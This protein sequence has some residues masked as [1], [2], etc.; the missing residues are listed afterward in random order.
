MSLS[1]LGCSANQENNHETC[2]P[3]KT[4]TAPTRSGD[5]QRCL[6]VEMLQLKTGGGA[7]FGKRALLTGQSNSS[8]E[9][10]HQRCRKFV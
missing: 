10:W 7:V 1:S 8:Y 4:P 5:H 9:F 3:K 2:P 6:L